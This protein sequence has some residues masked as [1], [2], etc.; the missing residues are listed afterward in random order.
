MRVPVLVTVLFGSVIACASTHTLKTDPADVQRPAL[1]LK[2]TSEQCY[3]MLIPA[4][5][6]GNPPKHGFSLIVNDSDGSNISAT[7]IHAWASEES[8]DEQQLLESIVCLSAAYLDHSEILLRYGDPKTLCPPEVY[9][10]RH[11]KAHIQHH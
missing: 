10:Y 2:P 7:Y 4:T 3:L 11:L 8:T 9:E 5:F 1:I 6:D